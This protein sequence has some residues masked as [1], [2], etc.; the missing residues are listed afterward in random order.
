MPAVQIIVIGGA[1]FTD[2]LRA[3]RIERYLLAQT[4]HARPNVCFIGT[5]S[6]DSDNYLTRFY[7]TFAALDCVPS[8]LSLFRRTRNLRAHVLAQ[9]LIFIGGGNTKSLLALWHD[10]QLP[11]LLREAAHAGTVLAGTSA[12]AICWFDAGITD[13]WGD[14]LRSLPCLGFLHGSCCPHY[15]SEIERRP[16]YQRLIIAGTVQPGYA[17]DDHAALHFRDGVL[18][19]AVAANKRAKAYQVVSEADLC[20]EAPL[21][22]HVLDNAGIPSTVSALP[23]A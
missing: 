17:L 10:W 11:D 18:W 4:A 1:G 12:G 8:H 6:G 21:A 5:A 15:D 19:R 16:V 14:G 23:D 13:S 9:H 3:P 22:M 2:A 20:A 7:E